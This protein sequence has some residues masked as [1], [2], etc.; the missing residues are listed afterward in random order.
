M[1]IHFWIEI[2]LGIAIAVQ[3]YVFWEMLEV[4]SKLIKL[5]IETSQGVI[6][7]NKLTQQALELPKTQE[8]PKPKKTRDTKRAKLTKAVAKAKESGLA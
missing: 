7:C 3:S 4:Q 2:G 8:Q 5:L 6:E 1:N